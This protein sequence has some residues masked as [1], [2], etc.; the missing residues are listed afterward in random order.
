MFRLTYLWNII[1]CAAVAILSWL[2]LRAESLAK[3][4][5]SLYAMALLRITQRLEETGSVN[6]GATGL[7][8]MQV[9]SSPQDGQ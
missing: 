8:A 1:H 5:S 9:L 4:A 6:V 7:E 2:S 3:T